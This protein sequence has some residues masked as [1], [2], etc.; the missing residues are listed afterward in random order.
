MRIPADLRADVSFRRN[1]A[2]IRN[3]DL[4]GCRRLR[5]DDQE[6]SVRFFNVRRA[7]LYEL[8]QPYRIGRA[9]LPGGN[10]ILTAL[11]M[12]QTVLCRLT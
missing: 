7:A 12:R 2:A 4:K 9:D 8:V 11:M 5:G 10:T 6:D 3:A 1:P